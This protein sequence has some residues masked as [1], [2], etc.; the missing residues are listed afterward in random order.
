MENNLP[1]TGPLP[2]QKQPSDLTQ[3]GLTTSRSSALTLVP[4]GAKTGNQLLAS[5]LTLVAPTGMN[6]DERRTWLS[7]ARST[8]KGIPED[9]LERGCAAARMKADHPA[10]I[11][12][13]IMREVGAAWETRRR[14]AREDHQRV[15]LERRIA[16][17]EPV[18]FD[19]KAI[20]REFGL[21]GYTDGTGSGE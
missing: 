17:P 13:E 15:P 9:L 19:T 20:L 4:C 21:G 12:P 11:I 2:E 14:I 16:P 8:L 5:C 10:K 7:V 6:A 18:K 1:A 3:V